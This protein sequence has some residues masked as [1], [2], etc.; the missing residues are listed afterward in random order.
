MKA[1]KIE[2]FLD[3][4]PP[5]KKTVEHEDDGD[6]NISWC[7]WNS[8]QSLSKGIGKMTRRTENYKKNQDDPGHSIVEIGQN[9]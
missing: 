9:T 8:P 3:L 6:T 5:P 7:T 1:K 4:A 2:K